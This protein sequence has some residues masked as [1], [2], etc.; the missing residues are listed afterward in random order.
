MDNDW[1]DVMSTVTGQPEVSSNS[2]NVNDDKLGG[3]TTGKKNEDEPQRPAQSIFS[4][5]NGT[6]QP[7]AS[8][9]I[10][11]AFVQVNSSG[12]PHDD[13][14]RTTVRS[15]AK[16]FSHTT[17][18]R[19]ERRTAPRKIFSRIVVPKIISQPTSVPETSKSE[20][21][22]ITSPP[23]RFLGE[24]LPVAGVLVSK[25]KEPLLIQVKTGDFLIL[26]R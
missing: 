19:P 9:R 26:S 10:G 11:F 1:E 24:Q 21:Q 15:N 14:S 16:R 25:P 7:K 4:T 6:A 12:K 5:R 13:S 8:S 2:R 17:R 18:Q 23:F 20:S 3:S 22:I